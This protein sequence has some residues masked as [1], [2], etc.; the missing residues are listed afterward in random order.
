MVKLVKLVPR[1]D[2]N[3]SRFGSD[4]LHE[5]VNMR[6]VAGSGIARGHG[7]ARLPVNIV[8]ILVEEDLKQLRSNLDINV[9]RVLRTEV[10]ET[11]FVKRLERGVWLR[12]CAWADG[13]QKTREPLEELFV[14]LDSVADIVSS[15]PQKREEREACLR[16]FMYLTNSSLEMVMSVDTLHLYMMQ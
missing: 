11:P 14:R 9:F 1:D 12:L 6:M 7:F 13:V 16:L 5:S 15:N 10:L 8:L 3:W 2:S 4:E